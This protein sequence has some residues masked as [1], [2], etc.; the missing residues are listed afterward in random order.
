ML[1]ELYIEDF[2]LVDRLTAR[3][4]PGLNVLT[5]ETGAGKSII[6]D[7]INCILGV[8]AGNDLVRHGAARATVQAA[9]D[10]DDAADARAE[11]ESAGHPVEEGLLIVHRDLPATGKT[12]CRVGGRLV[13]V[14]MLR[15]LGRTLIDV[16]GQHE[17]QSL[18]SVSRHLDLLDAW[19]GAEVMA[20][21]QR[22]GEC[23]RAL[24]AL[25]QQ[26]AQLGMDERDRAR[27][28]DLYQFQLKEIDA[29]ALQPDEEEQ[30][31][32][33]R[34]RL[35][36]AEKLFLHAGQG[37]DRL[38]D[39]GGALDNLGAALEHLQSLADIDRAA[40]PLLE[41]LQAAYYQIEDATDQ[42]R[43]YRDAIEFNPERLEEIQERLSVIQSLKRKY[44][45]SIPEIL[46]YRAQVAADLERL[47]SAEANEAALQAQ[48]AATESE[49]L[50]L[51]EELGRLR[52]EAT[53]R[54]EREIEAELAAL[55][56]GTTRFAVALAP[57]PLGPTGTDRAEFLIAP[58]PG[59]PLK[60]LAKIASGGEL[61]RVMLALKSV[62]ARVDRVP[63]LIFD[64]IDVGIG[65]RTAH[66]IG[67]KLASLGREKQVV[68]VTHLPQIAARADVHFSV[69]KEVQGERTVVRLCRLSEEER[70]EELSRMLGGRADSATA[71]E[72]ARE[73]LAQRATREA[74]A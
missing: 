50:A 60:P 6:I 53:R 41:A 36:N 37:Y 46:A 18:L 65:G 58:N 10:L 74:A 20:L 33:D 63:T 15:N 71:R 49:A 64:E 62:L 23:H 17:H 70:I 59:E 72:H 31:E 9:F 48:R 69:R 47:E 4:G 66:V 12:Q 22:V 35:A 44:G 51:A 34:L 40:T 21:R 32:S 26:L 19:A 13:T 1:S 28:V 67:E 73:L 25:D 52:R 24:A 56:M 55:A 30:L 7:A 61:S 43:S 14:A 27:R 54:F 2:A 16:H 42:L 68:C 38:R 11:A 29:A 3:F 45:D 8:R 5:G 39:D 57:Q